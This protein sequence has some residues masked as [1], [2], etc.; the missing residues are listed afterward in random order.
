MGRPIKLKHLRY[1]L[2]CNCGYNRVDDSQ[3]AQC[4]SHKEL[5]SM[6]F[7]YRRFKDGTHFYLNLDNRTGKGSVSCSGHDFQDVDY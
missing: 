3:E 2:I 1:Q 6:G 4:I 7:K 5:L